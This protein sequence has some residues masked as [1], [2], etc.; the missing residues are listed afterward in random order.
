MATEE[1]DGVRLP[2]YVRLES[3]RGDYSWLDTSFWPGERF[4][5]TEDPDNAHEFDSKADALGAIE[6]F[7]PLKPEEGTIRAVQWKDE[8]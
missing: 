1:D 8:E 4:R 3:N 5:V 6:A 2:W 7:G